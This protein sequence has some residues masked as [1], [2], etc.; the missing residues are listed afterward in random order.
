M[1]PALH[2]L[3]CGALLAAN[4][5]AQPWPQKV[6]AGLGYGQCARYDH[7]LTLQ[8]ASQPAILP[9]VQAIT[10]AHPNSIFGLANGKYIRQNEQD[11][12]SPTSAEEANSYPQNLCISSRDAVFADGSPPRPTPMG[13]DKVRHTGVK[14]TSIYRIQSQTCAVFSRDGQY[15][16]A[17]CLGQS[18]SSA[19]GDSLIL[20]FRLGSSLYLTLGTQAVISALPATGLPAYLIVALDY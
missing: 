11:T 15:V 6:K 14:V 4:A 3:L 20:A 1:K 19:Q 12:L 10:S 16:T 17:G 9:Q 8:Q 18:L 13:R 7:A 2:A 5:S